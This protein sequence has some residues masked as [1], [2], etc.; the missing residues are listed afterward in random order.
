MGIGVDYGIF[1]TS[2]YKSNCSEEEMKLTIQSI[3]ICALTTIAGFGTLSISSNY[4]IFS[5][6]SSI[7]GGIVMSFLTFYLALPYILGKYHN[8][9]I[10][11]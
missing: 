11:K 3:F 10:R 4:S 9:K 6:G 1:M 2:A 7:L 5:M 8:Y